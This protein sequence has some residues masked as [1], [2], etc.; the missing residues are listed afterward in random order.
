MH[1]INWRAI[2]CPKKEG[3]SSTLKPELGAAPVPALSIIPE[4]NTNYFLRTFSKNPTTL[5]NQFHKENRRSSKFVPD[6]VIGP[7]PNPVRYRPVLPHLLREL[8][9]DPEGLVGRLHIKESKSR[10]QPDWKNL[11]KEEKE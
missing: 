5:R 7:H 1:L 4:Q 9:L 3:D 11:Y 10:T 6:G 2:S 8:L